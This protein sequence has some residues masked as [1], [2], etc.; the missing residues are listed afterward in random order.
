VYK[1]GGNTSLNHR[2]ETNLSIWYI[3]CRNWCNL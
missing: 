3:I 1:D 2:S